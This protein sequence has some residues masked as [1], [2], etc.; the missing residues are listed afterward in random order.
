MNFGGGETV[1]FDGISEKDLSGWE[2]Y[3]ARLDV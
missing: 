2:S 1:T 3:K